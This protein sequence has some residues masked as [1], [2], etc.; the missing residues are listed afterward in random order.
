MAYINQY[1]K[2]ENKPYLLDSA[3]FYLQKGG[4]DMIVPLIQYY[5]IKG[6]YT[7][8]VRKVTEVGKD[9]LLTQK[10][11]KQSYTN[12]DGWTAYRIGEAYNNLGMYNEAYVFFQQAVKLTPYYPDFKNK[13]ATT[14]L[15]LDKKDEAKRLFE[16]LI[17]ENPVFAPAYTNLGFIYLQ[18]GND[19]KAE[20]LYDQALALDPDYE[21]ALL[22][23][24][25]LYFYRNQATKAKPYLQRALKLNPSNQRVK[26][27][28]KA[29][30]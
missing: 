15:A 5:Y 6:D 17:V 4:D 3:C 20:T 18:A 8:V 14:A 24:A 30:I 10:L 29:A 2:F 26:D 13:L 7:A 22:N 12:A 9:K 21:Q 25:G 28:L 23:K 1:E 11:I 27:M 19:A 16:D